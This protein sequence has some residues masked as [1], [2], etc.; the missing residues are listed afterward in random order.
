MSFPERIATGRNRR[1][2]VPD[3][4]RPTGAREQ[5]AQRLQ[6]L[7]TASGL[8]K[9][10]FA[11]QAAAVEQ[12]LA[13]PPRNRPR[14]SPQRISDWV[15]GKNIPHERALTAMVI[16][17]QHARARSGLSAITVQPG[18]LSLDRWAQWRRQA[19]DEASSSSGD[20]SGAVQLAA[21]DASAQS[22]TPRP[23]MGQGRAV[24][25]LAMAPVLPDRFVPR[26]RQAECV[27]AALEHRQSP[28]V[29]HGPGGFGKST[30]ASW[31]CAT[32][33]IREQF[34]DGVLWAQMGPQ[35][36]PD[37]VARSLSEM[38][39]QV[40]GA[41]APQVYVD[42]A[43]AAQALRSALTGLQALLVVD[44]VWSATDLRPFQGLGPGVQLLVTT[45]R[46]GLVETVEVE[47]GEMSVDEAV[48]VLGVDDADEAVLQP[49]LARAG[50][51][52]LALV[53]LSG[54]LRSLVGRHGKDVVEAVRELASELD[55]ASVLA[56][57]DL[58]DT[59]VARGIARTLEVSLDDLVAVGG[60]RCLE[61][62]VSLAAF[63]AGQAVP[64]ALLHQLWGISDVRARSEGDR[65]VGRSLCTVDGQGLRLHG[66]IRRALRVL[67]ADQLAGFSQRLLVE[68][69]PA[70]GW[71]RLAGARMLLADT[72]AFHLLQAGLLQ[73]LGLTVRDVRFL[74]LRLARSGPTA[75]DADLARYRA[76]VPDDAGARVLASLMRREALAF[77]GPLSCHDLAVTLE[78]RALGLDPL[79]QW[80]LGLGQ[81]RSGGGVR[82][83]HPPLDRDHPALKSCVPAVGVDE[84]H[85]VDWHPSGRLLAV[86]GSHP[87]V[88]ILDT[89]GT[90]KWTMEG[91]DTVNRVRW[92]PDGTRLALV[93]VSDRFDMPHDV[94]TTPEEALRNHHNDVT[95][96]D[97]RT[98]REILAVPVLAGL[99][100]LR[101]SPPALCWSP[102]S[103][104]IC[105]ASDTGVSLYALDAGSG[106]QPLTGIQ[107]LDEEGEVSLDWHPV[108]GL[109]AHTPKRTSDR[110]HAG[111]LRLWADP[112]DQS[113][114]PRQWHSRALWGR[115]GSLMWRP[116][117]RTAV[118]DLERAVAIV[119][120]FAQRVLWRTEHTREATAY[121]SADG[122]QLAVRESAPRLHRGPSRITVWRV[123]SDE[124][125]SSGDL[126]MPESFVPLRSDHN[127][128]DCVSWHSDSAALVATSDRRL[129]QMWD[130]GRLSPA[131]AARPGQAALVHVRWSSDG[132]SL[133]VAGEHGHWMTV[134]MEGSSPDASRVAAHSSFP[135]P[136]RDP[137][138]RHRWP[139]AVG[140]PAERYPP[141]GSPVIVNFGPEE[142]QHL[143]GHWF[144]P[145]RVFTSQGRLVTE[146]ASPHGAQRWGDACF[147]PRGD[148]VVAAAAGADWDDS[149]F[150]VWNLNGARP[151]EATA[152]QTYRVSRPAAHHSV[153]V[154]V[155]ASDTHAVMLAFPD[156]IGVFRLSDMH[157][158]CWSKTNSRIY[159]AAFDP[160]GRVL[161]VVGD[162][163]L[164]FFEVHDP[165]DPT[166]RESD[167]TTTGS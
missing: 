12:K 161:T 30:L 154:R 127:D 35:V 133:A 74:A 19:Q 67:N 63:P 75:V 164:H 134:H 139:Q 39:A 23:G 8:S 10:A 56:L 158:L 6:E 78:N 104:M 146:L 82:Y 151:R 165:T 58:S 156:Y 24:G 14:F 4:D 13:D 48:A 49:L 167:A 113:Q 114:E 38:A 107:H 101:Q 87:T 102:D 94:E 149:V 126:P 111:L 21:H 17:V 84:F 70:E 100:L 162:A 53:M 89:E 47:V 77:T 155:A 64:F 83:L 52:P 135:F 41:A 69:R 50:Y 145:L 26:P 159:D 3:S 18:L 46:A 90:R 28:V 57:D 123:P 79:P 163:G 45:R 32:P 42:V 62:F 80:L 140:V 144:E 7:I 160:S 88:E 120:P 103:D 51:W 59:D 1:F 128:R 27:L 95:V 37:R 36:E 138:T 121:W 5:F 65:F 43:A 93:G 9:A 76:A 15:L 68:F 86:A 34:P 29:L 122:Q 115:G 2:S 142:R 131:A 152:R 150:S 132:R 137:A 61:R 81:A 157:T 147:T 66:I 166:V 118:L 153:I 99:S 25:P 71:H 72:L 33:Q 141:E 55:G 44:D 40:S 20:R 136:G 60:P 125:L 98:G 106:P 116:S 92:S 119:D 105:V 109:L 129:L 117:G 11:R 91:P 130:T 124:A 73:E 85:D 54:V 96:Y 148:R 22:L 31:V 108:H 16:A 110:H 112:A 97:L 143:I